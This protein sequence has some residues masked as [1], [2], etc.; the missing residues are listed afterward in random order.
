MK[1]LMIVPLLLLMSGCVTY[2]YPQ[3]AVRDGVYYAQDDPSHADDSYV[4]GSA[5][6]YSD[7]YPWASL[8]SFYLGYGGYAGG[9]SGVGWSFGM[10]YGFT[11][12]YAPYYGYYSPWYAPYYPRYYGPYYSTW[13][14]YYRGCRHRGYCGY[15]H[16]SPRHGRG[17]HYRDRHD[18]YSRGDLRDRYRPGTTHGRPARR[19]ERGN[20]SRDATLK[21]ELGT[22]ADRYRETPALRR[23]VTTSPA[24]E[25]HSRGMIVRNRAG[26]KASPRRA[27]PYRGS[28]TH[29]VATRPG[30]AAAIRRSDYRTRLSSGEIVYRAGA[31]TG[32]SRP[33]PVAGSSRSLEVVTAP[34]AR[35]A[36]T[37]GYQ[38]RSAADQARF[39]RAVADRAQERP[40]PAR[41]TRSPRPPAAQPA[42]GWSRQ[43][44]PPVRTQGSESKGYATPTQR[45]PATDARPSHHNRRR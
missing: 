7:Y 20:R 24:G 2:Y 22:R 8:D 43:A 36:V 12:W 28:G 16:D 44:P 29:A 19:I 32:R 4:S 45:A 18:R 41:A 15:Y 37:R 31:K 39:R 26:A 13:W 9:H 38:A 27:Q 35:P 34:P 33:Q 30:T 14:P 25:E 17:G 1:K 11:P 10:S 23:Y 3:E 42:R 40:R 6:Y 5:G 21:R